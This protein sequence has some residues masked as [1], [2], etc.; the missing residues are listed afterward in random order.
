MNLLDLPLHQLRDIFNKEVAGWTFDGVGYWNKG[1]T[2]QLMELP[3]YTLS[4]DAVWPYLEHTFYYLDRDNVTIRQ[5]AEY[6]EVSRKG[7][8]L[9]VAICAAL[10]LFNRPPP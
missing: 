4:L 7:V 3:D 8:S 10:I 2:R 6:I 5:R 1:K 9:P